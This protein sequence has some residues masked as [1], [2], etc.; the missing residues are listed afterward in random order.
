MTVVKSFPAAV[1]YVFAITSMNDVM[2]DYVTSSLVY[3]LHLLLHVN[4]LLL[5]NKCHS[6]TH[7]YQLSV[8]ILNLYELCHPQQ[9]ICRFVCGT[10]EI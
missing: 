7:R 8:L 3:D 5:L 6:R 1:V 4:K 2:T 10:E 9:I